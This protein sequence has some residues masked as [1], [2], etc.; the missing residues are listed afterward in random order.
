MPLSD[1]T[2]QYWCQTESK[3]IVAEIGEGVGSGTSLL[4]HSCEHKPR[5][6][7]QNESIQEVN[8]GEQ[9][10]YHGLR[11]STRHRKR[12]EHAESA[13]HQTEAKR[14]SWSI[15]S[16]A[17]EQDYGKGTA[18]CWRNQAHK[19]VERENFG[20]WRLHHSDQVCC[21]P[22]LQSTEYKVKASDR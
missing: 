1:N 22:E 6:W 11:I 17:V 7:S 18:Q 2:K 10:E 14:A 20:L 5:Q 15:A 21:G 9:A 16:N 3:N 12:E 13:Y 19:R 4:W 8:E